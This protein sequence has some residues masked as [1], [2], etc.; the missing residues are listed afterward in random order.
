MTY[1]NLESLMADRPDPAHVTVVGVEVFF[2]FG[3]IYRNGDGREFCI[4]FWATGFED[5]ERRIA[6]M[7]E[8]LALDGQIYAEIPELETGK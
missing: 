2:E 7:R 5:A 6:A 3:A 4:S 8:S 1:T